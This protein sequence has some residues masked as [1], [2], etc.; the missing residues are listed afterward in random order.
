M[1][2]AD[3]TVEGALDWYDCN[4]RYEVERDEGRGGSSDND[5][6]AR[7]DGDDDKKVDPREGGSGGSEA[8]SRDAG[9]SSGSGVAGDSETAECVASAPFVRTGSSKPVGA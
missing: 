9:R 7:D 5:R 4:E 2:A 1:D 3:S 6:L 8:R